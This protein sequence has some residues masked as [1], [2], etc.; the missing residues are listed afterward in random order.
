MSIKYELGDIGIDDL[1]KTISKTEIKEN[2][3]IIKTSIAQIRERMKNRREQIISLRAENDVDLAEIE[4]I[5]LAL[6]SMDIP[7][8]VE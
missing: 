1:N 7:D 6:P 5:K 3:T 8:E 2:T 4:A